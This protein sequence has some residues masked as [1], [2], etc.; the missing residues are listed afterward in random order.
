M[1]GSRPAV[2]ALLASILALPGNSWSFEKHY[3]A[4]YPPSFVQPL[5]TPPAEISQ[6]L[7]SFN[8][9]IANVAATVAYPHS[10]VPAPN[11]MGAAPDSFTARRPAATGL[12]NSF[13][14]PPLPP[15]HS[16]VAKYSGVNT[17]QSNPTST[18]LTSVGNLLTPPSNSSADGISPSTTSLTT[19]SSVSSQAPV[20]SFTTATGAWPP[21]SVSAAP[22]YQYHSGPP[23]SFGQPRG[24]FSPSLNSI[25][26]ANASPSVGELPPPPYDISSHYAQPLP[27][28][29]PTIQSVHAHSQ[30]IGSAMMGGQPPVTTSMAQSSAVNAQEAFRPPPTPGYYH[31]SQSSATPQ[32]ANFPYPG[33]ATL[34]QSPVSAGGMPPKMSPSNGPGP[35][36][37]LGQPSYRPY[38]YPLPG[39][40]LSNVGNPGGQLALVGG[41]G[42]SMMG[43][44]NSGH[45][46]SMHHMYGHP[47]PSNPQNDRPFRCDQCPQSFNRNHD[48]KRHKR[49]HLAVKPFPCGHCD[50]SFSRKDALKVWLFILVQ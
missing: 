11:S 45:A 26:R 8:Q 50:K 17:T 18:T 43:G 36:P 47:P 35:V 21:P 4:A 31:G 9:A 10:M 33:P 29:A 32:Q 46:A 22:S 48:L 7:S 28:S 27:M 16:T 24:I 25:V 49:I 34:Q 30:S 5:P 15:Y 13:A 20:Q 3:S 42:H 1:P 23:P 37:P 44:Y 19:D 40:V 41:M 14:L 39:P 12:S 38:S 2:T 6:P